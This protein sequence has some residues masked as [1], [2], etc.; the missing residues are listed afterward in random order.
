MATS[1]AAGHPA[2]HSVLQPGVNQLDPAAV[3]VEVVGEAGKTSVRSHAT[4]LEGHPE[5]L[6]ARLL[7]FE[8]VHIEGEVVEGVSAGRRPDGIRWSL[9]E[10]KPRWTLLREGETEADGLR[11]AHGHEDRRVHG[12]NGS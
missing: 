8:V 6:E 10:F 7:P 9:D 4:D 3:R 1:D 12:P 11:A 5:G 2:L